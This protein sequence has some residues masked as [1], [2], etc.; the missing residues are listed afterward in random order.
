MAILEPR[1]PDATITI[2][3]RGPELARL[4]ALADELG[5][6]ERTR[7]SGFVSADERD[8]LLASARVCA[9]PSEKEG[10]GLTVIESNALGTPVVATDADGLRDSVRDG[11]TGYLVTDGDVEGFASR[12][13]ELLGDQTLASRMGAAALTWSKR[14]SWERAADEMASA[15]D[16][17]RGIT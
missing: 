9:C 17:A 2:V 12:I 7:F 6:A 15:I 8:R 11:E 16:E 4:D 13:A 14:F 5:L 10:W 1:F 3:G